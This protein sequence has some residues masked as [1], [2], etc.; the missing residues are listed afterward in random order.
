MKTYI[1]THQDTIPVEMVENINSVQNG[2]V[3][4]KEGKK[5]SLKKE[6]F[7]ELNKKNGYGYLLPK[8]ALIKYL[9]PKTGWPCLCW[10]ISS[11]EILQVV[12][13][14]YFVERGIRIS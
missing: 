6:Y 14:T 5:Y 12:N 1:S 10:R 7:L 8:G 3:I 4:L 13:P 9:G 11:K 2:D